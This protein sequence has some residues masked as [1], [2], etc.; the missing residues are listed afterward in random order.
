MLKTESEDKLEE[1]YVTQQREQKIRERSIEEG[2]IKW[3]YETGN[4]SE[5][6][7]EDTWVRI[8]LK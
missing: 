4:G 3:L 6:I 7:F 1:S 5:A 2:V 8:L